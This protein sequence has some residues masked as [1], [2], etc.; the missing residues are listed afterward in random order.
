MTPTP[1]PHIC[2]QGIRVVEARFGVVL[3]KKGGIVA[4]L[5][6]IFNLGGGGIIGDGKQYLSWV[7]LRDAVKVRP[8]MLAFGGGDKHK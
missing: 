2:P 6:P 1:E 5:L 3:S 8:G 4:K 7:S